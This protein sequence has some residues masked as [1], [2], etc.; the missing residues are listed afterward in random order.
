MA[1]F[2]ERLLVLLTSCDARRYGEWEQQSW[3]D[4]S[5][6]ANRSP[7]YQRFLADGLTRSLV[8]AQA[9][10]MSARTGGYI[11]L[12]LLFDIGIPGR[13]ADRLLDGPT[14]DIWIDPWLDHLRTWGRVPLRHPRGCHQLLEPAYHLGFASPGQTGLNRPTSR[15]VR[16]SGAG[17][18]H[19]PAGHARD[20]ERPIRAST[21]WTC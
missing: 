20:S 12:Q 2:F 17:R 3:W 19:D 15:L 16:R 6:A 11:L 18:A 10:E 14:S 9:R 21:T 5:G 7:A 13:T 4:F 8:A 1:H